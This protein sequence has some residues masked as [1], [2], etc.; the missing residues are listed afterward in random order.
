MSSHAYILLSLVPS[1]HTDQE[2][3]PDDQELKKS[4]ASDPPWMPLQLP[5]DDV[6]E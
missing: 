6:T 4:T 3:E 2:A 1:S 5:H